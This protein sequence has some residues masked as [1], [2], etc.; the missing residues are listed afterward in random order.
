MAAVKKEVEE[1]PVKT[2]TK[3]EAKAEAKKD[4]YVFVT[5]PRAHDGSGN[6]LIAGLN[7]KMYK[8]KRGE[9]VKVPVDLARII[10][11]SAEAKEANEI[12]IEK[13]TKV[14]EK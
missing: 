8:I 3:S 4:E 11:A 13:V 12:F 5:V 10:V 9:P 2:E 1:T 14:S 7:G 6:F